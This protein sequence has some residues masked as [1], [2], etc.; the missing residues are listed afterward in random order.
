M[1]IFKSGYGISAKYYRRRTPERLKNFADLALII[2]GILEL[3]PEFPY[4]QWVV[5]LGIAFKLITKFI[6]EHQVT[7]LD[8]QA[9]PTP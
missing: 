7:D 5:F 3:A 6:A 2:S 4:K 1:K 9:K 8:Q